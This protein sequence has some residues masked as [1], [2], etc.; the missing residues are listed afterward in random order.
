[1]RLSECNVCVSD[2]YQ[3]EGPEHRQAF[4]ISQAKLHQTETNNNAIKDVPTLLEVIVRIQ[5]DNLKA[6]LC[7]EDACKHLAMGE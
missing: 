6:H 4:N 1:M 3:S 2:S 5:S 7:C